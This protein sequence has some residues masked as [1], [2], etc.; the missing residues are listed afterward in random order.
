MAKE[1]IEMGD[2]FNPEEIATLLALIDKYNLNVNITGVPIS[3][4]K[5]F[6]KGVTTCHLCSTVTTQ[7]IQ[8]GRYKDGWKREK[9]V[10]VEEVD[11]SKLEV[12][13][14]KVKSCYNCTHVLMQQPKEVLVK[15]IIDLYAPVP[16]QQEIWK[17]VRELR[18]EPIR[19]TFNA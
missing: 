10:E 17:Y 3:A 6:I 8:L 14:A 2:A 15:K 11:R 18:R 12:I 5:K 7:Y 13:T 1:T 16:T 19:V 4:E 9:D